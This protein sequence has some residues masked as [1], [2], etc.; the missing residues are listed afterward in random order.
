MKINTQ[1]T[2][3]LLEKIADGY[4]KLLRGLEGRYT[5]DAVEFRAFIQ[6][7]LRQVE[8][9]QI[10]LDYAHPIDTENHALDPRDAL[11]QLKLELRFAQRRWKR[12]LISDQRIQ[13]NQLRRNHVPTF[14]A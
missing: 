10:A 4:I 9:V 3:P 8:R 14:A 5:P 11:R 6:N 2:Q 7:K 12:K 1:L 13:R